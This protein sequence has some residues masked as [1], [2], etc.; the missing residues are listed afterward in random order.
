MQRK[1]IVL[2]LVL[3]NIMFLDL[4]QKVNIYKIWQNCLKF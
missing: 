4:A 2:D 1:I 3:G